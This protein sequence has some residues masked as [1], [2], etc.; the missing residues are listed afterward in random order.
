[1]KR[2]FFSLML[3]C[4]FNA[5]ALD[6]TEFRNFTITQGCTSHSISFSLQKKLPGNKFSY[7]VHIVC[8]EDE[9][10]YNYHKSATTK[11]KTFTESQHQLLE[12]AQSNNSQLIALLKALT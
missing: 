9:G 4:A 5:K 8:E 11:L 10:P 6:N 7:K 2:I 1:M 12:E 3:L